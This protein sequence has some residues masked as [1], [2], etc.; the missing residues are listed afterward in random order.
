MKI[1]TEFGYID[2]VA[3]FFE[4]SDEQLEQI[5]NDK[6]YYLNKDILEQFNK[7]K[8]DNAHFFGISNTNGHRLKI[9]SY[10]SM[11]LKEYKSVSWWDKDNEEFRIVRRD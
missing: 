11:L 2:A 4:L 8:G 3:L 10:F 1:L 6:S 7:S 5:R 9:Q